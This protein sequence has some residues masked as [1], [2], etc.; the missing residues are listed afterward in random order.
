[1][2]IETYSKVIKYAIDSLLSKEGNFFI[3]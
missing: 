2:P 1:M 3:K